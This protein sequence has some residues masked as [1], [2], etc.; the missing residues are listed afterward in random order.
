MTEIV[1]L[2]L[3]FGIFR[4]DNVPTARVENNQ[5]FLESGRPPLRINLPKTGSRTISKEIN[6]A[7]DWG[8]VLGDPKDFII[9]SPAF[10]LFVDY[11]N[12]ITARRVYGNTI[13]SETIEI[14]SQTREMFL[15][16]LRDYGKP[17]NGQLKLLQEIT[18]LGELYNREKAVYEN[19]LRKLR[20]KEV[21]LTDLL[22]EYNK[23]YI[24][25]VNTYGS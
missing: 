8:T 12:K 2:T 5:I 10:I 18:T 15:Q 13:T 24:Y 16:F 17:I 19:D 9:A 14:P 11:Q 23:L 1:Q 7:T 22:G 20:D 21:H 25:Y 6:L 4:T 3:E